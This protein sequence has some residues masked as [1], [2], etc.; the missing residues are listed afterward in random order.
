MAHSAHT[1]LTAHVLRCLTCLLTCS[2][3]AVC[4][5]YP[6]SHSTR[7]C[8]TVTIRRSVGRRSEYPHPRTPSIPI[9]TVKFTCY[10]VLVSTSRQWLF[11][12]CRLDIRM[13]AANSAHPAAVRG[14]HSSTHTCV[15]VFQEVCTSYLVHD[16]I[17]R[18]WYQVYRTY[19]VS[20]RSFCGATLTPSQCF[21]AVPTPRPK[22][23]PRNSRPPFYRC[24]AIPRLVQSFSL[25]FDLPFSLMMPLLLLCT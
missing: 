7:T 16:S 8:L 12:R 13:A 6:N 18:T 9:R 14:T 17:L 4:C 19:Q 22:P 15:R 3:P 1:P 24:P 21:N 5:L 10:Q 23:S 20:F 2:L 25:L 11:S